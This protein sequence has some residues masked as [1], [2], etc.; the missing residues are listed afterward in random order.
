M[1]CRVCTRRPVRSPPARSAPVAAIALTRPEG[2]LSQARLRTLRRPWLQ[3]Q[4]G[5]ASRICPE[6]NNQILF[7]IGCKDGLPWKLRVEAALPF[8]LK[9]RRREQRHLLTPSTR[10]G[11]LGRGGW[12]TPQF[13]RDMVPPVTCG[14]RVD[15]VST[16]TA[17]NFFFQ[18]ARDASTGRGCVRDTSQISM[19]AIMRQIG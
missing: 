7:C 11:T 16:P 8:R 18:G 1:L 12:K 17:G 5:S 14:S 2:R 10:S 9:L 15:F 6:Y 19:A 3:H 4:G 13:T